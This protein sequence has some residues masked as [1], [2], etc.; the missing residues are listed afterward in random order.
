MALSTATTAFAANISFKHNTT[1][2]GTYTFNRDNTANWVGPGRANTQRNVSVVQSVYHSRGLCTQTAIDG[3]FG[4]QTKSMITYLQI[5]Y[6]FPKD[7]QDGDCGTTTWVNIYYDRGDI[8]G[9]T[10]KY[11]L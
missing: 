10:L 9:Y 5:L 6:K 7:K 4:N 11:I 8:S 3:Y 1:I 2:G